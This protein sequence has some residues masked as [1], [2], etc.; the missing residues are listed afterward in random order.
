[1]T[2][3]S[4]QI[5]KYGGEV[6]A[7]TSGKLLLISNAIFALKCKGGFENSFYNKFI[8]TAETV[9]RFGCFIFMVFNIPWVCQE[10]SS[11]RVF[12][13]YLAVNSLFAFFY[14]LVCAVSFNKSSVFR[15]L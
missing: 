9:G 8:E 14:C 1:M 6:L 5:K 11:G 15:S 12:F 3:L 7:V 10:F 13:L 2:L 4:V